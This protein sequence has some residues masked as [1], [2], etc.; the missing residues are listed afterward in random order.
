MADTQTVPA[1]PTASTDDP[2]RLLPDATTMSA[3]TLLVADLESMSAYYARA[4]AMEPLEERTVGARLHRVLGRHRV[5]LMKLIAEPDLPSSGP[6]EA[7]LFHTAFVFGTAEGLAAA[8]A[9]AVRHPATRFAG[10]A[11]HAVSEAFYFTD[12]EGNGVELYRDRPRSTWRYEDG[13]IAITVDPLDPNAFLRHHFTGAAEVPGTDRAG[14]VGHV[15]LQVGDVAA[16]RSFYVD[17]LGFAITQDRYPGAL[18]AS[19]GG[20]HHHI[21]VNSWNS[22]GAGPRT[23]TLGLGE[24]AIRVPDRASL[25]ALAARVRAAGIRSADDGASIALDDRGA[26]T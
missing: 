14:T 1:D 11:D 15:H 18:F 3:P 21:A 12:P 8:V 4:L 22:R 5:P 17:A 16:A 6:R 19:A 7:G 25:D 10:T 9:D 24:I 2:E 13:R 26:R 20:Y 23:A